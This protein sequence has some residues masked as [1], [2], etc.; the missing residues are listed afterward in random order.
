VQTTAR[1]PEASAGFDKELRAVNEI[2]DSVKTFFE[3]WARALNTFDE[4]RLAPRVSD[5]FVGADPNGE[6]QVMSKKD[7]LAGTAERQGF[8][9]TIGFRSVTL[10]PVEEV[11]LSD[12]YTLVKVHG[13]MR[14]AKPSGEE[15]DM[16][17]DNAYVLYTRDGSTRIVFSL[18]HDDVGKMMRDQGIVPAEAQ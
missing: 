18:S 3:E 9:D 17:N 7:Y 14:L 16:I 15:V 5:P 12:R 11:P 1:L 4:G 10:V 6:V 8:M 2:S 13:T